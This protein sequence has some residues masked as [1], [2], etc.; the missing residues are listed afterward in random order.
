LTPTALIVVVPACAVREHEEYRR[1][2]GGE[3]DRAPRP[4][5]PRRCVI[6]PRP[7]RPTYA[8]RRSRAGRSTSPRSSRRGPSLSCPL[9]RDGYDLAPM[10]LGAE[11]VER[12]GHLRHAGNAPAATNTPART[13]VTMLAS[14]RSPGVRIDASC[15]QGLHRTVSYAIQDARLKH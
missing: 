11:I 10:R 8:S 6:T 14:L 3:S 7:R 5:W 4:A 1:R 12:A 15:G 2:P 13:T 9:V